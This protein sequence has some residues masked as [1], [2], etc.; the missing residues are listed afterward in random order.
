VYSSDQDHLYLHYPMDGD[1]TEEDIDIPAN[2]TYSLAR[3]MDISGVDEVLAVP[4]QDEKLVHLCA[5]PATCL[6]LKTDPIRK[7]TKSQVNDQDY[8][9]NFY[10]SLQNQYV[11]VS[12]NHTIS[13]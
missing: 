12:I 4:G 6:E 8:Y 3:K 9:F 10:S 11:S 1:T 5:S 13:R 7:G 2:S